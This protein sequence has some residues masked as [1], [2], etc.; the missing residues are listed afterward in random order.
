[1]PV[2]TEAPR[3]TLEKRLAQGADILFA[4]ELRGDTGP[5]YARWLAAWLE[6]LAEYESCGERE[7]EAA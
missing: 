2:L 6:L 5:E 4:M 1:M 7:L 3:Q